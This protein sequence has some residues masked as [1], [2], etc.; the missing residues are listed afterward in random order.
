MAG[1][2]R[3]LGRLMRRRKTPPPDVTLSLFAVAEAKPVLAP[4]VPPARAGFYR[5]RSGR[6]NFL[7][8]GERVGMSD[9]PDSGA[10]LIAMVP[11]ENRQI[12]FLMAQDLRPISVQADG[13][14]GI[15]VSA[16]RLQTSDPALIRL[17]H[18]LAP[19]RFLAVTPAGHGAPDGCV[20]FDS[21]GR[22]RLDVFEPLAVDRATLSAEF[23]ATAA[24]LCLAVRAPYR[25]AP[26]MDRLRDLTVRPALAEALMRILPRD[27]LAALAAGLLDRQETVD[28]LAELLPD[29]PWAQDVLPGLAAWQHLRGPVGPDNVVTSLP[30]DEFA[31]DPLEGFGQPQLGFALN[32][33]ARRL[34][35]PRNGACLLAACRNEGPYLLDWLAYHFAIGFEHAFIYTNDNWDGSE[36]LLA[37]LAAGGAIT[38]IHNQPG[39]HCGP[40]YKAYSHALSLLPQILDYAWAAVLDIDEYLGFDANMF[41]GIGDILA[42][43][44]TQPV[45]ALALC[46]QVFAGARGDV[47]RDESTLTRF[48]RREPHPNAHVKSLFRPQLFWHAQAHFPNA[49]LGAPYVFRTE[50]GA[51]HHHAGEQKRLAAFAEAPSAQTAWVNHYILRSAPEALWKLA[52]G[53]GDWKGQVAERH[54]DMARFVCR[55]YVALADKAELVEDRRILACTGGMAKTLAALRALPGVAD[56]EDAV[57]RQFT[58]RL[59]RM[60]QAFVTTPPHIGEPAEFAPFR[61]VLAAQLEA[62]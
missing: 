43:Q 41:G 15:A 22:T 27:E 54:L 10:V 53:H 36:H 19:M 52:R 2:L 1:V 7:V 62:V 31:G 14:R 24:E 30:S 13:M 37:A 49:T 12:C 35:R 33:L 34:I 28:L 60:V 45:D 56:A 20:I 42:W 6:G 46:W 5:L 3:R 32:G 16:Y 51:L 59:N 38:L 44:Q 50:T 39:T 21:L 11:D 4:A 57:K 8:A 47:W 23:L 26:L 25:M 58:Q 18:P 55:T 61:A 29:N 17:R 40:Q 9:A 48:T